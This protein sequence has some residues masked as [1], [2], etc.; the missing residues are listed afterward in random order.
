MSERTQV[1]A[2]EQRNWFLRGWLA[3]VIVYNLFTIV[4]FLTGGS[5]PLQYMASPDDNV[6]F[7]SPAVVIVNIASA[8][9][10]VFCIAI[11]L[12]HKVGYYGLVIA[13][14]VMTVAS[15][16]I[17][18][19]IFTVLV[20]GLVALITGVLLRPSWQGMK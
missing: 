8:A 1:T 11:W 15:L 19:N 5:N 3:L 7:N 13:Y 17:G 6:L 4:S 16:M 9:A 18:F 14:I 10:I 20:A 2:R 12:G